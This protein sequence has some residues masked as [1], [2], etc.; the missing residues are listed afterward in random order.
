MSKH[1]ELAQDYFTR[2][3]KSNECHITSDNRVFHTQGTAKSFADRLAVKEL[4]SF[5]RSELM[6]PKPEAPKPE[7]KVLVIDDFKG[8][9]A[10]T[11]TYEEAKALVKELGL[12]P[13][14][15]KKEDLF[16]IINLEIEK[17]KA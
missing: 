2:Y 16:A 15:N 12:K 11:A 5:T 1:T 14:S 6:T 7:N 13:S 10:D 3:P 4:S 17:I 8:F 9:N